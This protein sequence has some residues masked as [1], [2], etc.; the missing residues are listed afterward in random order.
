M[1]ILY[2]TDIVSFEEK[3]DGV[4]RKIYSQCKALCD[5]GHDCKL[6]SLRDGVLCNISPE[7]G[8]EATDSIAR[9]KEGRLQ[10]LSRK[11]REIFLPIPETVHTSVAD[12]APN[13]IYIRQISQLFMPR[14]SFLKKIKK[15]AKMFYE[16]PTYPYISE[17]KNNFIEKNG[18]RYGIL[19]TLLFEFRSIE[20]LKKVVDEF[21][22]SAKVDDEKAISRLGKYRLIP[23]GFDVSSVSV[24]TAPKL[25]NEI[26][27]LALANL[28]FW[29]GYDR[30][31]AGMARYNG[32]YKI[33]LH[34]AG[35]SG[36]VEIEKLKKQ[37]EQLGVAD[38]VIFY[39]P[40]YGDSLNAVFD[41]CHI[42]AGSLGRHRVGIPTISTLKSAEYCARGM[43]FFTS[44]PEL[45]FTD[46]RYCLDIPANEEPI[47]IQQICDF[48]EKIYDANHPSTLRAFAENNL[49][50]KIMM[51]KLFE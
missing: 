42:A 10:K 18:S 48:L 8:F 34:L 23:N 22:I 16:I 3:F 40:L 14:I 31:I 28:S 33:I 45:M 30:I 32:K 29:H 21:V 38:R 7:G 25:E 49:D 12:F 2:I 35:G 4:Q 5:L 37:A 13:I 47:E 19:L 24:R 15:S 41:K 11:L 6:L 46:F 39:E 1:R 43:P 36:K 26:H 27:I 9:C 20:R 44:C 50:W 51:A 17:L